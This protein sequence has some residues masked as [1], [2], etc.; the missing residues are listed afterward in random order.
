MNEKKEPTDYEEG[1]GELIWDH[2]QLNHNLREAEVIL[3]LGSIDTLPARRAAEL[4][5]A[6]FAPYVLFTGGSNGRNYELLPKSRGATTEA[7]M[8]AR[9]AREYGVPESAILLETKAKNSGENVRFSKQLL[10][11]KGINAKTIIVCHM[12]SAE[13]R[14]YA[15]LGKQWPEPQPEF[16]M[17]SPAVPFREY[18]K[19]GYQGTMSRAD[20]IN[21]LLGDFQRLFVF[22]RPEF[23]YM[24]S[25]EDL[26]FKPTPLSVKAAYIELV[27]RGY[28]EHQLVRNKQTG[29]PY[30]IFDGK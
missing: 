11:Q 17:N 5:H 2:M 8:L 22:S 27:E 7:E 10:E 30:S 12:P 28:G 26:G 23:G 6:E 16:I 14:D 1:L 25:Q 18:H 13:R 9:E 29:Q 4:Y 21:D 20:L 24:K 3:G 15:T 19:E